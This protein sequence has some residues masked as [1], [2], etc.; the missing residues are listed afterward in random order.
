[1]SPDV[2]EDI[3]VSMRDN[4]SLSVVDKRFKTRL[5]AG[6]KGGFGSS[7]KYFIERSN[8]DFLKLRIVASSRERFNNNDNPEASGDRECQLY[9]FCNDKR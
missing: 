6:N 9:V 5:A 1:M 2:L 7:S 8:G 4:K 3:V